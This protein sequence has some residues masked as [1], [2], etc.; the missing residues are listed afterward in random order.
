MCKSS[1][2]TRRKSAPLSLSQ[3]QS[4]TPEQ[5]AAISPTV[6]ASLDTPFV[7]NLQ[8]SQVAVFTPVSAQSL[9][10][11]TSAVAQP[12]GGGLALAQSKSR[13]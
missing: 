2:G 8:P 5:I 10:A 12:L 3:L 11:Y 6:L 1:L 9:V 7:Q 13:R 4:L